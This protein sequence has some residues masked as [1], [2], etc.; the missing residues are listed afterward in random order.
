MPLTALV[1]EFK[2]EYARNP[3]LGEIGDT[4]LEQC[5]RNAVREFSQYSP[6]LNQRGAVT[7]TSGQDLAVL[8][9][10]FMAASMVEL[11]R[12]QTGRDLAPG[13]RSKKLS[14][15]GSDCV[16]IDGKFLEIASG[17]DGNFGLWLWQT[18]TAN[19][20]KPILFDA[21]HELDEDKETIGP[22]RRHIL[23]ELVFSHAMMVRARAVSREAKVLPGVA[24]VDFPALARQHREQALQQLMPLGGGG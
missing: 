12:V 10:T 19:T 8:P 16:P 3:N 13:F 14:V 23:F 11:Y 6:R 18:P 7:I 5:F 21:F 1:E 15:F 9:A 20:S 17:D 24:I 4:A 22:A 2:N